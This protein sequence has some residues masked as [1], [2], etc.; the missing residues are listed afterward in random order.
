MP[1][2]WGV[3]FHAVCSMP[4]DAC[5]HA[6]FSALELAAFLRRQCFGPMVGGGEHFFV[7]PRAIVFCVAF[8]KARAFLGRVDDFFKQ[9][10]VVLSHP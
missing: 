6:S 4:Y 2:T 1:W 3:S 8:Q 10:C 9:F 5:D 7:M